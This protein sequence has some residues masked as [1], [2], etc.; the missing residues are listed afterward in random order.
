MTTGDDQPWPGISVCHVMPRCA[1]HVVGRVFTVL[2]P[3]PLGPRN[4]SQSP[5]VTAPNCDRL[6]AEAS[7]NNNVSGRN[8]TI[9]HCRVEPAQFTPGRL[10]ASFPARTP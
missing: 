5:A 2:V 1:L 4:W 10:P 7:A 6:S 3:S 8:T 9:V